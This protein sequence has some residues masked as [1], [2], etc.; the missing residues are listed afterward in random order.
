M[1]ND[2]PEVIRRIIMIDIKKY[3][4][5]FD[6][7]KGYLKLK[8]LNLVNF[9]LWFFIP[10]EQLDIRINGLKKRFPNRQ[11]IPFARRADNDDIACFELGKAECVQII[12]DFS[13]PGYE[14]REEYENIWIWARNAFEELIQNETFYC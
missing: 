1:G 11:L 2:E 3:Y 9:D 8:S 10:D 7:P 4:P 6:Y 13:S 5:L 14:Q 12:H